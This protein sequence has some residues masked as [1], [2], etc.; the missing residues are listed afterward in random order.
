MAAAARK[1]QSGRNIS[2]V[3]LAVGITATATT[4]R[5]DDTKSQSATPPRV[6]AQAAERGDGG[7]QEP[8]AGIF[9]C[10]GPRPLPAVVLQSLFGWLLSSDLSALR[11]SSVA[12]SSPGEMPRR[13]MSIPLVLPLCVFFGNVAYVRGQSSREGCGAFFST[14]AFQRKSGL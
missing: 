5:D 14:C 3:V 9:P 6:P 4:P 11:A 12:A 1:K 13:V 8:I 10:A 7:W 2:S